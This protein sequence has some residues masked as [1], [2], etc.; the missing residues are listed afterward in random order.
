MSCSSCWP[1]AASTSA[2][3]TGCS[4]RGPGSRIRNFQASVGQVPDGFASARVLD[5]LRADR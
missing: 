5:R 4:A 3:P 1:G 2:S